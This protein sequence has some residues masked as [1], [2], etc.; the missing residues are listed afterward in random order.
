MAFVEAMEKSRTVRRCSARLIPTVY[1][2][3][4]WAVKKPGTVISGE[5]SPQNMR[6]RSLKDRFPKKTSTLLDRIFC[7]DSSVS[8]RSRMPRMSR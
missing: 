4:L 1:T 8:T 5:S 2:R 3:M 6:E 7:V